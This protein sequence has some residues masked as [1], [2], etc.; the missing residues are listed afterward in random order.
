M[1]ENQSGGSTHQK[2]LLAATPTH[3]GA[4]SI[5][6]IC[7]E[8]FFPKPASTCAV[9]LDFL[10]TCDARTE[11]KAS[12]ISGLAQMN[13]ELFPLHDETLV[14]PEKLSLRPKIA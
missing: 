12:A 1:L 5:H 8:K 13:V 11:G 6:T 7:F 2:S 9:L 10:G 3:T 4:S 14:I